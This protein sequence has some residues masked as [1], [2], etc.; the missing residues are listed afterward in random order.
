MMTEPKLT[1]MELTLRRESS[2]PGWKPVRLNHLYTGGKLADIKPNKCP[3][4][5]LEVPWGTTTT[6]HT[7]RCTATRFSDLC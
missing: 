5:A 4:M 3:D 2:G 6:K 7:I 1:W